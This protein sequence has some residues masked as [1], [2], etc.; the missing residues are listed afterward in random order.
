MRLKSLK[1]PIYKKR[2]LTMGIPPG[3]PSVLKMYKNQYE[4]DRYKK[5]FKN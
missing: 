4:Y 2:R 3:D 5:L 1:I